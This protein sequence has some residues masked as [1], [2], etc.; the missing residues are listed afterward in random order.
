[1]GEQA[2]LDMEMAQ[3]AQE[4]EQA[5]RWMATMNQAIT[6][7]TADG[8]VVAIKHMATTHRKHTIDWL[9]NHATTIH[10]T[11]TLV[12]PSFGLTPIP[13]DATISNPL[14]WLY[15]TPLYKALID[16]QLNDVIVGNVTG[17]VRTTD[18]DASHAASVM[19]LPKQGQQRRRVLAA[20]SDLDVWPLSQPYCGV[21]SIDVETWLANRRT[22]IRIDVLRRRITDLCQ[23]G[24]V[25][26]MGDS[27]VQ[28]GRPQTLWRLSAPARTR[29]GEIDERESDDGA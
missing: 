3:E 12:G 15:T 14:E 2:E 29:R 8:E 22:P 13:G 11:C 17:Q 26:S 25:E 23:L 1:M 16:A 28:D 21:T 4:R 5:R 24:W 19:S 7:T 10:Q 20:I 18:R 9:R 6:W 27:V